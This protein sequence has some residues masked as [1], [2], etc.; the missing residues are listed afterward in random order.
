MASLRHRGAARNGIG[1]ARR[2]EA[3]RAATVSHCKGQLTPRGTETAA[4]HI[5]R[6]GQDSATPPPDH[7]I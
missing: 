3:D 5:R 7:T 1:E 2:G 6:R 4:P